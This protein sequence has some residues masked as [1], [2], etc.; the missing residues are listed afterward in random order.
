MFRLGILALCAALLL[1]L[2]SPTFAQTSAP[3]TTLRLG[4]VPVDDVMPVLYA[5]RE[6]LFAKVGLNVTM[7]PMTGGAIAA[8][9]LSGNLDL[10]K[11]SIIAIIQAHAHGVPLTLVAPSAVYDPKNPDAVLAVNGDSTIAS[12]KDLIGKSVGIGSLGDVSNVAVEAWLAKNGV[13]W[14]SVQYVETVIPQTPQ[15]LEQRRVDA[16]VLIKPFATEPVSSGK[17]KII[18]LPYDA[19]APRFLESVWYSTRSYLDQH[20]SAMLAFQRVVAQAS[21]YTNA[22]PDQTVDLL[23]S[24]TR[25]TPEQAARVP[26]I[27]T[28][29]TLNPRE[30]QPIIDVMVRNHILEKGFDAREIIW[31]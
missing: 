6:G 25:I 5:Q 14:H 15:L 8:A 13:D 7:Q 18:A 24:F 30:I 22:H 21:V 11:S 2:Q 26:R 17:A 16:A 3:L 4:G 20:R 1:G 29:T 23:A 9:V 19:I 31:P 10:G 28:G 27:V 12:A